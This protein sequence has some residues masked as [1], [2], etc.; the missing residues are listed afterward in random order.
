VLVAC[1][2]A[3]PNHLQLACKR[4]LLM[5]MMKKTPLDGVLRLLVLY[6]VQ[7]RLPILLAYHLVL[8][9]CKA[10]LVLMPP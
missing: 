3:V 9:P 1:R 4:A 6:Q 7:W 5:M 10:L 2:L 8:V